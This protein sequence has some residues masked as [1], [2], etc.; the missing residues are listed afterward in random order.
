VEVTK[1]ALGRLL[2]TTRDEALT[3]SLI[4]IDN[5]KIRIRRAARHG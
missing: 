2:S 4:L 3:G 5:A 1:A